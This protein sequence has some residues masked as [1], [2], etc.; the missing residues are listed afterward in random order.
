MLSVGLVAVA[1][2]LTLLTI[3]YWRFTSPRRRVAV[4]GSDVDRAPT[5]SEPPLA[6]GP[7]VDEPGVEEP[8]IDDPTVDEPIIDEPVVDGSV[9]ERSVAADPVPPSTDDAPPPL[10]FDDDQWAMLTQAVLDEY[11][12]S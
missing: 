3:W 1:V 9:G 6:A 7:A 8:I 12:E 4:V 2:G 11:L 10:G 5:G